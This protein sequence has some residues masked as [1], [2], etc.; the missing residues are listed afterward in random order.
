MRKLKSRNS[1]S[2]PPTVRPRLI[3]ATPTPLRTRSEGREM[4]EQRT[5][6][7]I[8]SLEMSSTGSASSS[9]GPL[10]S[11]VESVCL[12]GDCPTKLTRQIA[13][14]DEASRSRSGQLTVNHFRPRRSA[15]Y[16]HTVVACREVAGRRPIS[17]KCG[18]KW[19]ITSRRSSF[20]TCRL[21]CQMLRSG[22]LS[23]YPGTKT[24]ARFAWSTKSV[25]RA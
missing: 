17:K 3:T 24:S 20:F 12:C 2:K 22:S 23:V 21:S 16:D 9:A 25:R 8:Y 5:S 10:K 18:H 1:S 14:S 13:A 4:E 15:R 6:P 11:L 7:Q 19:T